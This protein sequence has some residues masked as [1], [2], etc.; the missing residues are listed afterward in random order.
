MIREFVLTLSNLL[1]KD[2][3][4]LV[5]KCELNKCEVSPDQYYVNVLNNLNNTLQLCSIIQH[6]ASAVFW[7]ILLQVMEV[8]FSQ[9]ENSVPICF[10]NVCRMPF[11]V[12]AVSAAIHSRDVHVLVPGDTRVQ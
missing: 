12:S 9:F 11:R 8:Y 7:L 3:S 5:N 1:K 2:L 10:L 4:F 6:S